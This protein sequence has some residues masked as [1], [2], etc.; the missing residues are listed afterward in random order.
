MFT[1]SFL[2]ALV[3]IPLILAAP[4]PEGQSKR[5]DSTYDYVIV[6]GGTAGLTMAARLSEDSG[7]TVAVIE[8]GTFYQVRRNR[9]WNYRLANGH[10]L[11]TRS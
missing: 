8:A 5:A 3:A 9:R 10:R 11:L 4:A 2:H 1:R 7:T 6:G